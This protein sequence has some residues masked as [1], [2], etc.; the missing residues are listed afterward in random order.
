MINVNRVKPYISSLLFSCLV[1]TAPAIAGMKKWVDEEG[2]V[3]YGDRIPTQYL[4]KQHDTINEQG[5]IVNTQKAMK[6]DAELSLEED[7]RKK[8][9]E[10][11]KLRLVEQR[12]QAL[13]DR[14]LLDTFTTEKDIE[15]AR[16]AR[17]D[18][19]DSQLSLANTLIESDEK[20]LKKVQQRI[21][22]IESTGRKV[23]DNLH[24]KVT[25][26]SRQLENSYGFIED[27]NVERQNIL[28]NFDADVK[29]FR[30]LKS[31]KRKR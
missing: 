4:S 24:K 14:V 17:L 12:K 22:Q 1:V 13:R 26:V 19:L 29:R 6:T 11:D 21:E 27:K 10:Q 7:A 28:D 8:K 2:N 25:S 16:D 20:K 31:Q 3:H 18:A 9:A 15:F 23:P 5:L 30:E